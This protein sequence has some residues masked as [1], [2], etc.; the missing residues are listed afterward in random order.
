MGGFGQRRKLPF[1]GGFFGSFFAGRV[2][3]Q[4]YGRQGS[5]LIFIG[6]TRSRR[7][8]NPHRGISAG[9]LAASGRVRD[10][11]RRY[12]LR[13]TVPAVLGPSHNSQPEAYAGRH[14]PVLPCLVTTLPS[15]FPFGPCFGPRMISCLPQP[16]SVRSILT[17]ELEVAGRGMRD[18]RG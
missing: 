6:F 12:V 15:R 9:C 16:K 4:I 5:G 2:S 13:S 14:V 8:L 17:V 11:A 7:G 10:V 18:A 1:L 3:K